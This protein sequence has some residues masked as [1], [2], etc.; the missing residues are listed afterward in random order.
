ML[1]AILFSLSAAFAEIS[2]LPS[3]KTEAPVSYPVSALEQGLGATVLLQLT[4]DSNG[5]VVEALILES[6]DPRF[7]ESAKLTLAQYE[8]TPALDENSQPVVSQIQYRFVFQPEVLP[9][10]SIRGI[11]KEAGIR[12]P[13]K[14]VIVTAINKEGNQVVTTT[15]EDGAFQFVGLENGDW[16]I[17]A[18]KSGLISKTQLISVSEGKLSELTFSLVRDQVE[19]ALAADDTII[20][21]AERETS[22][23]T[24]KT[25]SSEQIEVLP[26]SNGD[27]V[28][29][30]QNLPG[31][32]RAPS[33][34][35]QLI[36]RGTAP[37]DSSF[38]IDG[39]PIP[40]VFHFAGLTTVVS[41]SNIEAVQYLSGNYSVR[42]GRQLGGLVDIQTRTKFPEREAS[43]VSVDLYQSAAYVEKMVT[44]DVVVAVSGRRSYADVILNPIFQSLGANFRTPRY[45]DFQT[46][47]TARTKSDGLIQGLFFLSDDQFSFSQS[48]GEDEE[49]VN[50]AYA[51]SFQKFQLKYTQPFADNWSSQL[52]IG[53]GPQR[54]D[55]LFDLNGESYEVQNE[56]NLRQEFSRGLK[57][58]FGSAFRAGLDINSGVF[59]FLYDL[60]SYPYEREEDELW[61]LEPALYGEYRYRGDVVDII[62]G[63]RWDNYILE[64]ADTQQA[65]DPRLST[66]FFLT[67]SIRFIAST[68]LTSQ[69]PLPRERSERND[70]DPSLKPERSW[71]NSFGLQQELLAGALR[72]QLIGYYNELYDLVVGRE[73]RFQFFTGPPPIG[74][75]DTDD[76][77]NEGTG[78]V[79][80]TELEVRYVDSVRFGLLSAT[81]GHSERTDRNGN[82]RLFTYDQPV[83]INAIYSQLLP[84]NWRIGGRARFGSGNPYT[85]V[86]NRIYDLNEREYIPVYSDE[87][88]RLAPFFSLDIRIDKEY[89]FENWK[90]GTYL[91]I[92]NATSYSNVEVMSWSYD[93]AEEQPLQGT[94]IFPV[95]G[96]KGE[97]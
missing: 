12:E 77:A 33:G 9:A 50:A 41:P 85:P 44:D 34:I 71:Q 88:D 69:A 29:A 79:C 42:Y 83:I 78:M 14:S 32:A 5:K 76:Y 49:Q 65:I 39:S 11:V 8:F 94:P 61:Y 25:L 22:E 31:I 23:V 24:V 35:G 28:K 52:V 62:G 4:I 97:W 82:T 90:L 64:E 95:F 57:E 26:G 15:E 47:A 93:Y 89:V 17:E 53:G 43:F 74:P 73:D 60:P 36:I 81:F 58:E 40:D 10:V 21:E 56:L 19:T 20:V 46:Q 27:V 51:K 96:L 1:N 86:A 13:L 38:F 45:Y 16:A 87:E 92:Q 2:V 6:S 7:N 59:S 75:F 37:E 72:W 54:Q 18:S 63:L 3:V 55:F 84:K 80:G 67:D 30:I 66:R 48:S 70:G 91:D 68:G